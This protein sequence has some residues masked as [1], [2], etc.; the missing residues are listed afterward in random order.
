MGKA[1]ASVT[2]SREKSG[3]R[4]KVRESSGR[5]GMWMQSWGDAAWSN[6]EAA[7]GRVAAD[8]DE[9]RGRRKSATHLWARGRAKV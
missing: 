1:V 9:V 8:E 3:R 7:V 4:T 2:A 6:G 5:A